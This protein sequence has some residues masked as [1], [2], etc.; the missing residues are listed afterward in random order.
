MNN[1]I[2]NYLSSLVFEKKKVRKVILFIT[3]KIHINIIYWSFILSTNFII[4]LKL[5][6]VYLI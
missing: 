4:R 6:I 3:K 5:A 1:K 2:L